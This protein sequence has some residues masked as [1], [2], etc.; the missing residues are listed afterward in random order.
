VRNGEEKGKVG[1]DLEIFEVNVVLKNPFM[2][3]LI[4]ESGGR[5]SNGRVDGSRKGKIRFYG[6]YT[7]HDKVRGKLNFT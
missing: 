1:V 2:K 7:F 5:S 4:S 3:S 6:V